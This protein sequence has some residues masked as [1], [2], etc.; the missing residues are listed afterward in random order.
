MQRKREQGGGGGDKVEDG[1]K[2]EGGGRGV[3]LFSV[4]T[5][6]HFL[7]ILFMSMF[8]RPYIAHTTAATER[9]KEKE[10]PSIMMKKKFISQRDCVSS[11]PSTNTPAPLLM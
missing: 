4:L 3:D 8:L 7:L 9:S 10:K 1:E 11:I 6:L 2:D 5:L